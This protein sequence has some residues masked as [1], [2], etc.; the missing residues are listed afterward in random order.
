MEDPESAG[1]RGDGGKRQRQKLNTPLPL[2]TATQGWPT[3]SPRDDVIPALFPLTSMTAR[4]ITTTGT[5]RRHEA[6]NYHQ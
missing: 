1:A 2:S 5:I 4:E 6:P 3:G